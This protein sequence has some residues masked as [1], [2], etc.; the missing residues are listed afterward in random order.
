MENL[1]RRPLC[2][3]RDGKIHPGGGL[4]NARRMMQNIG[5][6]IAVENEER[7]GQRWARVV[8]TVPDLAS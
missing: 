6:D 5:G 8:L 4:Y 1:F 2:D 7:D 3:Q